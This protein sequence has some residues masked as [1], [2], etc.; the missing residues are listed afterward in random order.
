MDKNKE[1]APQLFC[2][3][4]VP[5]FLDLIRNHFIKR[6][7]KG[8]SAYRGGRKVVNDAGD[9]RDPLL[10]DALLRGNSFMLL[11]IPFHDIVRSVKSCILLTLISY[12]F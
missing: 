9:K 8:A 11:T 1:N 5:H 7:T 2:S 6:E 12:P 10:H 3:A 4:E